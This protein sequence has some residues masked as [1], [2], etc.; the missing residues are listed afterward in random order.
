MDKI[1]IV[2]Y[3]TLIFILQT[4][5]SSPS[6]SQSNSE[7][8]GMENEAKIYFEKQQFSKALNLYLKLDNIKP[9]QPN[10]MYPIA[11]CY[12]NNLRN[13]LALPYLEKCLL[14]PEKYPRNLDFY[15][16][17]AYQLSHKFDDAII[18]YEIYKSKLKN[19]KKNQSLIAESN[20]EIEI[21]NYAKE[22]VAKPLQIK[23]V[24]L[25]G[26]I[27]SE[28]ADYGPVLSAD[29]QVI[30]FT[31]ARPNTTGGLIDDTDGRYY[32]DIYI[33]T[34]SD[35]GW[36]EPKQIGSGINTT[37]NDASISLSPDGQKLLIYRYQDQALGSTSSGDLYISRL[38]G[39]TWTQ[40]TKLP[41]TINTKAWE[42]SAC[43]SADEKILYFS[44]NKEGGS[45]GTDI[46]MVRKL[47]NG[48]WALP[49]NL[50]TTI[51]T[52]FDEDSP[53]IHPDGKT[54]YFSSNGHRTMGGYD[55]FVSKFDDETKQ[56]S[57]PSNVGYPINTAHDDIHFSWS[58]D[59]R[60]VYFSSIRPGGKG[61]NDI[62]YADIEKEA[63]NVLVLKGHI[64][65][66]VNQAPVEA[67]IKVYDSETNELIGVY[68]SNSSTGKFIIIF[69]EP[70][71]YNITIEADK[72]EMSF[73]NIHMQNIHGFEE[74]SKDILLK[75]KK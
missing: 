26:I 18:H 24:N 34:K 67:N 11:V 56:W 57:N 7:I 33:S 5:F 15:A 71:N 48:D 61:D 30:I 12:M 16:A 54:L 6:Y 37:G 17:K 62:Y 22:M 51:N 21:C 73:D 74:S 39:N 13:D 19:N 29:E 45:G 27:N 40:A 31:S 1:L 68:N 63:A 8:V 2:R 65:D 53:F 4:S 42:P 41:E 66:A 23:I 72:Y 43:L 9:N 28:Y 60:R 3:L 64:I 50:G 47:P 25:G 14:T 58:A 10:Y 55:I 69:S 52:S 35:S 46:Y 75:P 20:R 44:S 32:E 36:S 70:K 49:M 59:A 38:K